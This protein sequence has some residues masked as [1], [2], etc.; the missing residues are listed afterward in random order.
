MNIHVRL[1][2]M[3]RKV[4]TE[5]RERYKRRKR[6]ERRKIPTHPVY[7]S[8]VKPVGQLPHV[9]PP[10]GS[11]VHSVCQSQ[12]PLLIAH[13]NTTGSVYNKISSIKYVEIKR[14][15]GGWKKVRGFGSFYRTVALGNVCDIHIPFLN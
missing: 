4:K 3:E 11:G 5:E 12:S 7:P 15:G 6:R 9:R 13:E 14:G 2:F 1:A 10:P 8:P